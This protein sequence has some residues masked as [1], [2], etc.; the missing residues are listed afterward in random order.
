VSESATVRAAHPRRIVGGH[1]AKI[2]RW[3]WQVS[4]GYLPIGSDPA[5]R[6]GCGGTLVAPTIVVTAAHCVTL[7]GS[8]FRPPEEFGVVSGRTKLSRKGGQEHA[9][10]DYHWFVDEQ[11]RPLWSRDTIAWDVVFM[12][13][14]TPSRQRPI[15]IAGPSEAVTWAPG[16]RAFIT[17]WGSTRAGTDDEIS[18]KPSKALRAAKVRMISDSKCDSVY[19]PAVSDE[20]MVC[21]GDLAGG[22]DACSGD[23]GGPL[24]VA[25]R[26][27]GHRLIGDTSWA[28][29]CGL[30]GTPGVYGRL[31]ADPIRSALQ[32]GILDVAGVGVIG[33]GAEPTNRVRFGAGNLKVRGAV[34]RMRV[35]V[36]G[37]GQLRLHGSK[38][39]DGALAYPVRA[40]R[41]RLAIQP[42]G[43]VLRRLNEGSRPRARVEVT[44]TPMGGSP[45]KHRARLELHRP[46]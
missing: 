20:L 5:R 40:G 45:R 3:P 19:G 31:A 46:R 38:A 21:A 13:L 43:R 2:S 27:G 22:V 41:L 8:E 6:H 33:A 9:V 16:R 34:A 26:G 39:I 4:I 10:A 14:A 28:D 11:G 25:V 29:G 7:G 17:G 24:V 37:R 44:Y 30:P 35:S 42:R 18:S 1:R 32:A 36:P 23:S 12:E 15:K